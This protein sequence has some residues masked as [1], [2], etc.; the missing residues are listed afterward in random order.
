MRRLR[1]VPAD[2]RIASLFFFFFFFFFFLFV[3]F[4][5]R[6]MGN[7]TY[8]SVFEQMGRGCGRYT[9]GYHGSVTGSIRKALLHGHHTLISGLIFYLGW[10]GARVLFG[11]G[12]NYGHHLA[13]WGNRNSKSG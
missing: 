10:E 4:F 12:V 11:E 6:G 13:I 3:G 8:Q 5:T 2:R 9:D 1:E 7:F